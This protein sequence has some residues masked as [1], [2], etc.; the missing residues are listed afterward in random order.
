MKKIA[1]LAALAALLCGI[2]LYGY[3]DSVEKRVTEVEEENIV[4]PETVSVVVAATDIPPFMEITDE[5]LTLKEYP[6]DVVP[7]TAARSYED[8]VGLQTD[9]TVVKD[10][11]LFTGAVGTPEEIGTNLSYLIPEGMRAMTVIIDYETGVGGYLTEGDRVDLLL[12][13]DTSDYPDMVTSHNGEERTVSGS[14]VCILLENIEILKL[15]EKGYNPETEGMYST[16]TLALTPDQTLDLMNARSR[17][18]GKIG[19]ALRGRED[20]EILNLSVLS[21]TESMERFPAEKLPE[22]SDGQ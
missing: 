20:E 3:L 2:L 1:V 9:G 17:P 4:E 8:V 11:M 5:M 12:Y 16:V 13:T 14:T 21:F 18:D 19:I 7:E 22:Q 6:L 10:A 15:G